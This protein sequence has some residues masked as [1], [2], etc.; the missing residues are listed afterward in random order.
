MFLKLNEES[1]G[2]PTWVQSEDK[3]KYIEDYRR[4]EGI[5]LD[6]IN[7]QKCRATY[8]GKAKIELNVGQMGTEPKQ[9]PDYNCQ[10]SERVL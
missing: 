1:S 3:N 8:F 7:F 6:S 2:Y 4:A 9:G 5:A 10:F